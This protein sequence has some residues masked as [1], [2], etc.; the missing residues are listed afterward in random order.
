MNED[1]NVKINI[2]NRLLYIEYLA[3]FTGS[4][5]RADLVRQFG[6][7][8]PAA[9]IAIRA[10]LDLNHNMLCYDPRK[11]T[12]I[13]DGGTPFFTHNVDDSLF[14]LSGVTRGL[15]KPSDIEPWITSFTNRSIKREVS[16]DLAAAFARSLCGKRKVQANYYS[17]SSGSQLRVLSPVALVNDGAR[18]HVRCFDHKSEAFKDYN[19]ARFS[20]VEDIEESELSAADDADIKVKV[21]VELV[22]HPNAEHPETIKFDHGMDG[23]VLEIELPRCVVG[24]FL[25]HWHIDFSEDASANPRSNQ[26][27]LK[28]RRSLIS[29]GVSE[30]AFKE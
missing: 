20:S 19:L 14:L 9:T 12:Y 3:F 15:S 2:R 13:Y 6:I 16:I 21:V 1:L 4:V 22:A 7:S 27:F 18:W 28:N 26:L 8:E 30:W 29:Q 5:S 17:Q 23:E 11:K 25:R 10:Y 24:Y